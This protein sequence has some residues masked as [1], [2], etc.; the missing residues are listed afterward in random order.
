MVIGVEALYYL[1]NGLLYILGGKEK[2]L[3]PCTVE[4]KV[5]IGVAE[6]L[7]YLHNGFSLSV[8]HGDVKS[9]DILLCEEFEP[10]V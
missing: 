1:H 2:P 10:Q 4:L 8:I 3:F 6:S 7:Y 5:A 9:F